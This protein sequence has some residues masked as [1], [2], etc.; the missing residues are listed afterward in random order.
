DA[1]P[2]DLHLWRAKHAEALAALP[3]F[4]ADVE[5][6]VDLRAAIKAA[7]VEPKPARVDHPLLVAAR[8][9]AGLHLVALRDRR[10]KQYTDALDLGRTWKALPAS[11][12]RVFCCNYAGTV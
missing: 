4:V 8:S 2:F 1:M 5:A 9:T 12:H 3:A 11:V 6:L 10:V 7:P